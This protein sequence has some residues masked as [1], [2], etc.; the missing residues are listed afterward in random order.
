MQ[1]LDEVTLQNGTTRKLGNVIPLS[2]MKSNWTVFGADPQVA[3]LIP[4]SEWDALLANYETLDEF[5]PFIDQ[6]P[7]HDQ[8]GV[9][10]CNADDTV[11]CIE[12]LRAKQGLPSIRLS[13]ADLY[14]RINGGVDRG[15][16]LEDAMR[17]VMEN[18]VGTAETAGLIWKRGQKRAGA[19]ERRRFKVTEAYVCPTFAHCFSAV[20]QGFALSTGILWYDN[21]NTDA[22]GWLPG[23]GR[24]GMGGHAVMGYKPTKRNGVYAIWHQNSWSKSWGKNGRM[25]IPQSLYGGP[26]GGWWA[27]RQ[28]VDEGVAA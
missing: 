7:M 1:P 19:D 2:S 25:A 22:E 26:V 24:G 14:D 23:A 16:L 5:D 13:A 3:K 28:V 18:G 6:C 10:Q 11:L 21:F 4:Q 9:G 17:E 12:Y 20:L 27:V 8:N 15:S